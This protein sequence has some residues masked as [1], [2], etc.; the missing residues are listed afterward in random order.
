MTPRAAGL[1]ACVAL[2]ACR[3]RPAPP[4]PAP[5]A[6]AVAVEDAAPRAPA[7]DGRPQTGEAAALAA[8][9]RFALAASQGDVEAAR[10]AAS[11]GCVAGPCGALV[12]ARADV[13]V[14]DKAS[15]TGARAVALVRLP[16]D[17]GRCLAS[18]HLERPCGADTFRVAAFGAEIK[19]DADW[20]M[21]GLLEECDDADAAATPA[22]RGDAGRAR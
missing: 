19:D 21:M 6:A 17:A 20:L 7:S 1:L 11:P 2:V 10:R 12:R 4:G 22:P 16:C 9:R 15:V 3:E 8:T 18:A 13:W 14:G 5:S